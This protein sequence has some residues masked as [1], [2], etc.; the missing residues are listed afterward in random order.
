[1]VA[2]KAR[3]CDRKLMWG[4]VPPHINFTKYDT[5]RNIAVHVR[6]LSRN[7]GRLILEAINFVT[8]P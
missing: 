2:K 3:G 5:A 6:D 4:F 8:I 7:R 1:M